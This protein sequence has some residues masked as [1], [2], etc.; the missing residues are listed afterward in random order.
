MHNKAWV[1]AAMFL[2][3]AACGKS[4]SSGGDDVTKYLPEG[5]RGVAVMR[6]KQVLSSPLFQLEVVKQQV[7]DAKDDGDFQVLIAAG[8][9]PFSNVD[10]AMLAGDPESYKV[11]AV[12]SGGFDAAKAAEALNGSIRNISAI[13]EHH[14][15]VAVAVGAN[16]IILGTREAVDSAKAG[17]GVAGS[18]ALA[19]L[20]DELDRGKA[21]YAAIALPPSLVSMLPDPTLQKVQGVR[22]GVGLADGVDVSVSASFDSP[23]S[24]AAVKQLA[25]GVMPMAKSELPAALVDGISL[26][27]S[28]AELQ[29]T[30][31]L[32]RDA[33]AGD[34]AELARDGVRAARRAF[35]DVVRWLTLT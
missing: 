31:S 30:V 11:V 10:V 33:F 27:A 16:T 8:I 25:D 18:P 6:V 4:K 3:V 19:G 2:I 23:D 17:K 34:N 1:A 21:V 15:R 22:I 7:E 9:D 5:S 13:K 14:K 20:V 32:G 26:R 28:G 35:R 12:F 24:A 29:L